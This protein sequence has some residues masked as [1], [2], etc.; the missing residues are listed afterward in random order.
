V[1]A[2]VVI[3]FRVVTGLDTAVPGGSP[4]VTWVLAGALGLGKLKYGEVKISG[5][6]LSI[7]W[8]V[9]RLSA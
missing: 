9:V 5:V 4:P 7:S 1:P 6:E 8:L 3:A 2:A